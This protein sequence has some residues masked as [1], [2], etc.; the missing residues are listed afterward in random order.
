M[1]KNANVQFRLYD[2]I[3]KPHITEK[4]TNQ[5]QGNQVCFLVNSSSNKRD[6]KAAVELV[7]DV[8][9]KAVNTM[10]V[11]GKTKNFRGRSG[12]RSDVKKA[13]ITLEQGHKIDMGSGV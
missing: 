13:I 4:T 1:T 12:V 6:I 3:R 5:S 11:K 10:N 2:V 8:K 9:V 7:F